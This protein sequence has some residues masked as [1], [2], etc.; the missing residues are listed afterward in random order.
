MKELMA[1]DQT[2]VERLSELLKQAETITQYRRILCVLLR[3]KLGYSAEEIAQLL[4][5]V[6]TTV[7]VMHS[8]WARH[9]DAFFETRPRGGRRRENL[10]YEQERQL[11][12]PFVE[13]AHN[14]ELLSV[15]EIEQTYSQQ[16]GRKETARTTIY[17]LLHRH[18]WHK[19]AP[20][21]RRPK[22]KLAG[23]AAAKRSA[24]NGT[25]GGWMPSQE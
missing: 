22:T 8:N 20:R 7:H 5:L 15:R 2:T 9:G 14:G 16:I 13:R 4:G 19:V 18:G 3:I 24:Q 11:L 25:P 12:A 6:T 10:S 1:T 21:Q 17:R 23:Q